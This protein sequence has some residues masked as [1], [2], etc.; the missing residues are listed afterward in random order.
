MTKDLLLLGRRGSRQFVAEAMAKSNIFPLA[1]GLIVGVM[2]SYIF[3]QYDA[4]SKRTTSM[5][6]QPIFYGNRDYSLGGNSFY[7]QRR[8]LN[9]MTSTP[10]ID[11]E[12]TRM[13]K[14]F[15]FDP[16]FNSSL[17]RENIKIL[18]YVMC[19][20]GSKPAMIAV[21][22]VTEKHCHKVVLFTKGTEKD[23]GT[24]DLGFEL[25]ESQSWERYK[26]ATEYVYNQ[27]RLDYDLF[28]KLEYD[29]FV[30][31]ENV[32][33]MSLLHQAYIP[34]YLG[35]VLTDDKD[36]G[37]VTILTREGL[38]ILHEAIP[39]CPAQKG[40]KKEDVE[41]VE[42]LQPLHVYHTKESKDAEGKPR[43]QMLIP[44]HELPG[45]TIKYN[46]WYMRYIHHP[47]VEVSHSFSP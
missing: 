7:L 33:F 29:I 30:V 28:I 20:R 46:P 45:N 16:N 42:C 37:V 35:H 44:D 43:F 3:T 11:N 10:T 18:C 47:S 25:V 36:R 1:L 38:S 4:I 14:S 27:F 24:V 9:N 22:A 5:K 12:M 2:L 21:K 32:C 23:I 39:S 41:L 26:K 17:L 34:G 6:R 15:P 19:A 40:G 31:P 8:S 13:V